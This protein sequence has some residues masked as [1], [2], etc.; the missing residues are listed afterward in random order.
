VLKVGLTG[1]IASGKSEAARAFAALG[2]PVIDADELARE[3]TA[4]GSAGLAEIVASFGAEY[5]DA[6]GALNRE[7]LRARVFADAGARKRLEAIVHPR[8]RALLGERLAGLETPYAISVV[9][10]L[11]ETGMDKEMDRVL[12]VDCPEA[13]QIER[14][15]ARDGETEAS[16]RTIL[17]TQA[18]RAERLRIADDVL[19]NDA[20]L[21]RLRAQVRDLND[22]YREPR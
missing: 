8:V 21:E 6:D 2:A 14:I 3:A 13:A 7:K 9:P 18:S 10:L 12:V 5:L 1:G 15:M 16:A 17:R 11:V 4:P 22:R 19:M 20:G